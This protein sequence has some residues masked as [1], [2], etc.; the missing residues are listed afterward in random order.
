MPIQEV[1]A[2]RIWTASLI[3]TDALVSP[4]AMGAYAKHGIRCVL[5]V[6]ED[7]RPKC[8]AV[9]PQLCLPISEVRPT[10]PFYFDLACEFHRTC[11]PILVHCNSGVN[12]STAFAAALCHRVWGTPL[13]V[14]IEAA[15]AVPGYVL[16]SMEAWAQTCEHK[17]VV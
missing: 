10:D 12:R 17:G 7:V 5:T 4:E 6:A 9:L 16:R 2:D 1:M 11:G 8:V 3:D 13:R 15:S 14:A